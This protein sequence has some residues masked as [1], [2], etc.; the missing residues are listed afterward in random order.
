MRGIRSVR[1][2]A[3]VVTIVVAAVLAVCAPGVAGAATPTPAVR[4]ATAIP[5]SGAVLVREAD[6]G[7][8]VL[9][10]ENG[11]GNDAY[12]TLARGRV[13][14]QTDYVR[15]GA[16]ATMKGIPDGKYVLFVATGA[17]WDDDRRRFTSGARHFRFADPLSYTTTEAGTTRWTA[18]LQP[19]RGGNARTVPVS[20][21]S[22]PR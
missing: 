9:V 10:V 3:C 5:A 22:I 11:S 4:S 8:G 2:I 19:V 21:D 7:K 13:A 14:V 12:V 6:R 16:T 18:T 20:A 1:A 15:A 17:G